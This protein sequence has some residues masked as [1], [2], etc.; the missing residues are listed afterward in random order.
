MSHEIES[1]WNGVDNKIPP[2]VKNCIITM[3]NVGDELS[4]KESYVMESYATKEQSTVFMCI[5]TVQYIMESMDIPCS[6]GF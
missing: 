5:H 4:E 1:L 2:S 6:T 3:E